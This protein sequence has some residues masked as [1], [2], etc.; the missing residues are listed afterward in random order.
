MNFRLVLRSA[1][2][3]LPAILPIRAQVPDA[4]TAG[5]P[6]VFVGGRS[7]PRSKV[8]EEYD[9]A[10]RKFGVDPTNKNVRSAKELDAVWATGTV[11]RQRAGQAIVE[12]SLGIIAVHFRLE[13]ATATGESG[14]WLLARR[15]ARV[16]ERMEGGERLSL[17]SYDDVSLSPSEFIQT[18]NAGRGLGVAIKP[19]AQNVR[20]DS[21]LRRMPSQFKRRTIPVNK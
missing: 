9:K 13:S 7:Y 16:N 10:K 19:A 5:D 17:D 1:C 6:P 2:L 8:Q 11:L 3:F 12:S 18:L 15:R 4:G 14:E 21:K 20:D